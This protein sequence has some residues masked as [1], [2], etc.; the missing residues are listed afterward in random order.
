VVVE[1]VVGENQKN[2]RR[3]AVGKGAR[4]RVDKRITFMIGKW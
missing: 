2:R 3:A 4:R 1:A